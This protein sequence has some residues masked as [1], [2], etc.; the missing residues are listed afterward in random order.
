MLNA[1][2]YDTGS[3]QDRLVQRAMA[4]DKAHTSRDLLKSSSK[5]DAL[6]ATGRYV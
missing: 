5:K 4:E 3:L 2:V 6:G 1:F